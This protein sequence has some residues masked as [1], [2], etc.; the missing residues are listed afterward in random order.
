[1][2]VLYLPITG[3][4][5]VLVAGDRGWFA[6]VLAGRWAW[7]CDEVGGFGFALRWVFIRGFGSCVVVYVVVYCLCEIPSVNVRRRLWQCT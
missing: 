6:Y 1:M 7:R 2:D 3:S 4:S 5:S